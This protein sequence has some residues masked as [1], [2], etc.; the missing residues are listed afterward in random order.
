M[1][2]NNCFKIGDAEISISAPT[3]FI[4][5]IAAN[6]DGSLDR[7]RALIRLAKEAGADCVKFQH[8]RADKIVSDVGFR[9]L[10]SQASHQSRWKKSV[11]ETYRDAEF[12]RDW[13]ATLADEAKDAGVHFMTTPYDTEAVDQV[14]PLV[15]AFKIGS[16]D[17]TWPEF[18]QYVASKGKPVLLACGASSLEDTV[19]A[20][21]TAIAVNPN[22]A[23]LQ[24][25]TNYTGSIENFHCVNLR[26]LKQL[27]E[28]YPQMVVGL[29]DHTPGHVTV[30][31]AIALGARVVEKHF[32]DDN[33]RE[34]PDHG[35]SMNPK[36]WREMIDRS[37]ELEASLGDGLKKVEENEQET[38]VLQRRCLR[39]TR[40]AAAGAVLTVDMLEALRPAPRGSVPPYGLPNVV[41]RT[42]KTARTYGSALNWADVDGEAARA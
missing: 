6:H 34:G 4:A 39:L 26:A 2:Y 7:A 36:T 3:Y 12:N 38:V 5:D 24:C 25:N 32:T 21:E 15:L 30:L 33:S 27:G 1:R 35:F 9:D 23:L 29:S 16:G 42:L 22:F 40:D 8:F 18:I 20:V 37:R 11:F 14:D 31:G 13:N 41:G 10:G 28:L 19:R 17:V